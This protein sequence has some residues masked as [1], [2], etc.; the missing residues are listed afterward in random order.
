MYYLLMATPGD[1]SAF[2]EHLKMQGISAVFHYLPLHLSEYAASR[3]GGKSGDCPIAED[4]SERIVRLPFYSGM[5][6]AEQALV[7]SAVRE[8]RS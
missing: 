4:V 6:E 8:W 1:R 5:T 3:W 2:I 7:V